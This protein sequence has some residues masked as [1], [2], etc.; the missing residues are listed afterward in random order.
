MDAMNV[1]NIWK[2]IPTFILVVVVCLGMTSHCIRAMT[3]FSG[4]ETEKVDQQEEKKLCQRFNISKVSRQ[5]QLKSVMPFLEIGV[6][7]PGDVD[8]F[9][10]QKPAFY[11]RDHKIP[12]LR[13][14]PS[15][16][17]TAWRN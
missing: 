2:K 9:S 5:I 10:Y 16:S 17:L 1:R 13:A 11:Q 6:G 15:T 4:T 8:Y 12:I 14:P 3:A 7:D